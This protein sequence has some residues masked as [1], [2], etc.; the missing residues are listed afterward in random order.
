MKKDKLILTISDVNSTRSYTV[1]MLIK[2]ILLWIV[3]VIILVVTIGFFTI[4]NLVDNV[5]KLSNERINISKQNELFS[6]Q[7]ETKM[8]QI[9]L[10]STQLDEIEQIIGIDK[11]DTTTLIQRATLAKMT[12]AQKIFMLETIPSGCPLKECIV[13]SPFGWRT[14]PTLH[15]KQFHKGLDL[16]AARRTLVRATADGVVRYAQHKNEGTFGRVIIIS[17]NF[18]FETVYGHLRFT[19]VKVGD[20][21]SKGQ[22]IARSGNSG[23]SNGPHLHYEVRYANKVLSPKDFIN[24]NMKTYETIFKKQRRVKWESLVKIINKQNHKMVQQ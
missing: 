14:H 2:K 7:I 22:V 20:V 10:L 4:S 13:T 23:R 16:R 1:S 21:V 24:W 3:L 5:K 8:K 17:H 9:K 19:D 18:G 6:S 15:T 12:S 11:D